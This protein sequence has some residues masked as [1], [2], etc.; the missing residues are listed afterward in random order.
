M[1]WWY[2]L[3]VL[4]GVL[5]GLMIFSKNIKNKSN[6]TRVNESEISDEVVNLPTIMT[7]SNKGEEKNTHQLKWVAKS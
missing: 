3:V 4:V 2:G 5:L 6:L 1:K 7:T